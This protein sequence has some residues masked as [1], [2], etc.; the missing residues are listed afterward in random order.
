M[1][2]PLHIL[3]KA[4]PC[5][6]GDVEVTKLIFWYAYNFTGYLSCSIFLE[7]DCFVDPKNVL[8]LFFLSKVLVTVVAQF[9]QT[10]KGDEW[11]VIWLV[12][13][14]APDNS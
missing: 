5:L 1:S 14:E 6:K 3:L 4:D 10:G 7:T 13:Q 11:K 8:R 12:V 2:T 9:W